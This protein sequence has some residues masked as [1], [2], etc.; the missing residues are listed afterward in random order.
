[1]K[2]NRLIFYAVFGAFH[3]F[4]VIFTMY[5]DSQKNDFAFLTHMLGW[6]SLM[7]YGAMF[8]LLL[9]VT[10][11]V[12]DLMTNKESEKEKAALSHEINTLKAKLFDLQE[13]AKGSGSQ[14]GTTSTK[15]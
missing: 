1:M 15:I 9:L 6:L 8:G 5:I 10:D 2:K 4:L 12:W 11:V 13:A 14:P 3:L 7:K